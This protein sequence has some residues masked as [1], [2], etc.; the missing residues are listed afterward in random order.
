MVVICGVL[1][2]VVT[3]LINNLGGSQNVQYCSSANASDP[4]TLLPLGGSAPKDASGRLLLNVAPSGFC[5]DWFGP[6]YPTSYPYSPPFSTNCSAAYNPNIC[7]LVPSYVHTPAHTHIHAQT[8][9]AL[10]LPGT[11]VCLLV[12]HRSLR[13]TP[14]SGWLTPSVPLTS[15]LLSLLSSFQ[16]N[17]WALVAGSPAVTAIVGDLSQPSA[18]N[19]LN[20]PPLTS[21]VTPSGFLGGMPLGYYLLSTSN[22]SNPATIQFASRPYFENV[23]GC[24]LMAQLAVDARAH[25][26]AHSSCSHIDYV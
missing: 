10:V 18:V 19:L 4:N 15:Q 8:A 20:A 21:N 6:G 7:P 14:P 13:S 11:Y 2:I 16:L 23:C 1:G 5:V 9:G 17:F 12:L 24:A 3:G 26:D 22:L 25:W